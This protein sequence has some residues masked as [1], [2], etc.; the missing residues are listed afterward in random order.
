MKTIPN[1][2]YYNISTSRSNLMVPLL[3]A[4]SKNA[5]MK[6]SHNPKS[7]TGLKSIIQH[8]RNGQSV[9][10]RKQWSGQ[11]RVCRNLLTDMQPQLNVFLHPV[12]PEKKPPL[13]KETSTWE[14]KAGYWEV[15]REFEANVRQ[16]GQ[17]QTKAKG[18]QIS[19]E[20]YRRLE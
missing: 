7:M 15:N 20:N 8:R 2:R 6:N 16:D 17:G 4:F 11:G 18:E 9:P 13:R 19:P 10:R 5:C 3:M 1:C 12:H 14:R